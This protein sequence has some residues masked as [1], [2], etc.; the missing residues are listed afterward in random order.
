VESQKYFVLTELSSDPADNLALEDFLLHEKKDNFFFLYE[1]RDSV[2][3]GKHQNIFQEVQLNYCEKNN[4]EVYRRLSGGGTV[5]HG[6]GNLNFTFIENLQP[7][8]P[9][10]DFRKFL[11]PIIQALK[12]LGAKVEWS[13]RNDLLLNGYKI[14]GNAQHVYQKERRVIHHGTLLFDADLKKLKPSIAPKQHMEF[15]SHAVQSVR[16]KVANLKPHVHVDEME[17]FK[18]EILR[19]VQNLHQAT[20]YTLTSSDQTEIAKR[21]K[22]KY[23][24]SSWNIGYSPKFSCMLKHSL[25]KDMPLEIQVRKGATIDEIFLHDEAE[26]TAVLELIDKPFSSKSFLSFFP[27]KKFGLQAPKKEQV[28]ALF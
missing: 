4:V 23:N 6:P 27:F 9:M 20:A 14:S 21:K 5:F 16:S 24:L 17:D 18:S 26:K 2:I 28:A 11:T 3:I 15:S 12:P 22:D 13:G 19:Y 25:F 10:I 1:N 7:G 8:E